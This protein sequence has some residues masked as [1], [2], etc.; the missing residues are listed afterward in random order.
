MMENGDSLKCTATP[1]SW[2][3]F[4]QNVGLHKAVP[5]S[6][7]ALKFYNSEMLSSTC[8]RKLSTLRRNSAEAPKEVGQVRTGLLGQ[9]AGGPG[10]GQDSGQ[11]CGD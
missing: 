10:A 6:R 9:V 3:P 5:G 4:P 8:C 11:E 1:E 7:S 2:V